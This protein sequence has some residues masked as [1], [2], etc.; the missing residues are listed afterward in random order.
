MTFFAKVK[1]VLS[2]IFEFLLPFIKQFLTAEGAI[3]LQIAEKIVISLISAQL[4]SKE[5]HDQAVTLIKVELTNQS[6]QAAA[7][8]INSAIE[9][10]LAKAKAGDTFTGSV[11]T[12][13]TTVIK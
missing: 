1:I 12:D 2:N 7:H 5:K 4:T 6:I 8:V 10:A 11:N 3:I 13:G 9:A